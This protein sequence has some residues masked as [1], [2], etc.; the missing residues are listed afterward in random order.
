MST[1]LRASKSGATDTHVDFRVNDVDK[2]AEHDDKV[3]NVPRV[4]EVIL[5]IHIERVYKL[6]PPTWRR[7]K[8]NGKDSITLLSLKI[9]LNFVGWKCFLNFN[10]F[11]TLNAK[12]LFRYVIFDNNFK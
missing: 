2:T 1:C 6:N 3:K 12:K 10:T 5:Q 11:K 7:K 8:K 9:D 4:A